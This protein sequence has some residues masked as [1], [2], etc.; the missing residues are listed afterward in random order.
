MPAGRVKNA[1][2]AHKGAKPM[3]LVLLRDPEVSGS[4]GCGTSYSLK[5]HS[6]LP[7]PKFQSKQAESDELGLIEFCWK[8]IKNILKKVI[9]RVLNVVK[10]SRSIFHAFVKLASNPFA[11]A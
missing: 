7:F 5:F 6:P 4:K 8:P 1:G 2:E 11:P 3:G 9:F 10:N